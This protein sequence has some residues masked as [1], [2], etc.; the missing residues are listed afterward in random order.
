LEKLKKFL[1][2]KNKSVNSIFIS[3]YI[4]RKCGIATY[5]K[6]LTR[7]INL[8]NP[9]SKSEI[10]A[11]IK[12]EDKRDYPPEVKFKINQYKVDSY[13]KAAGY[14]NKSKAD[15]VILEHEFGLYGGGC[16]EYIIRLIELIKKPLIVTIHTIPDNASKGYGLVLKEVIKFAEKLITMMPGSL[17]KL[18]K[19]YNYPKENI[20]IIPHGVPDIPLE[21]NDKYKKKKGLESRI[22]LGNINLLSASKGLEY[23][24]EALEKIKKQ[25]NNVLYLII[26]QTHP[27]VLQTEGEKYRNFLKEKIREFN[28]QENVRFINKYISLEELMVWLKIIDI[29]ITPYLDSQQSASGALAYAIGAGKICISTP[30]LYAKEVLAEGRGIIVPFRNSQAIADAVIDICENPQ[31]KLRIENKTYKFGRLMT[32]YNVALQHLQLFDEVLGKYGNAKSY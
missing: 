23:T 14:I 22:I 25:F 12:P 29:Y 2:E 21:P 20:E 18:V 32:W 1:R 5:T 17:Q 24:I 19:K 26:G 30:Y 4:P 8:I 27:V 9:Y 11:L 28:L 16:G 10:V 31:K 7:A 15:I 13:I 3:S 6:D